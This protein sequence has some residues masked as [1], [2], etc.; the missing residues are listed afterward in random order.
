MGWCY[1]PQWDK[2]A[3]GEPTL[4]GKEDVDRTQR[5]VCRMN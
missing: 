4:C 1:V 2:K 3:F 5:P